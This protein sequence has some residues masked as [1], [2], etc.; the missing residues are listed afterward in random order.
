MGNA[1]AEPE[2]PLFIVLARD[3]DAPLLVRMWAINRKC[4]SEPTEVKLCEICGCYT[5]H[6]NNICEWSDEHEQLKD[7]DDDET[8]NKQSDIVDT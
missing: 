4:M 7:K 3:K 6:F 2:E 8:N 1:N 5:W